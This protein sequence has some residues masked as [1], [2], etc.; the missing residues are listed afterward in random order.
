[1]T[2]TLNNCY[3][4]YIRIGRIANVG[5]THAAL[6]ELVKDTWKMEMGHA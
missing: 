3:K 5:I 2:E 1:V 6:H 4:Y